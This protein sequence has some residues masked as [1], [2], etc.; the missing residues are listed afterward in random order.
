MKTSQ[1]LNLP[2]ESRDT[3]V[4]LAVIA[5]TLMP[6]AWHLPAWCI[7]LTAVLL[8]WRASLAWGARRLPPTAVRTGMLALVVGLTWLSF[9]TVIGKDPG[10]TL[11]VMLVV[12]KTLE[13]RAR[14]D[15][16]VVFF[17][18]FFL[19]ITNFFYSQSLPV[20]LAMLLAVWGLLTALVL[21][22]IP[23]G[24]P[25]LRHASAIA[26]RMAAWSLPVMV[27]MFVMFPRL[28]PLWGADASGK[29]STGL[30]NTLRMGSIAEL[31]NNTQIAFRIKFEGAAPPPSRLYFRGP[32]LTRFDGQDW[33]PAKSTDT[34]NGQPVAEMGGTTIA[35]EMA[36][37]P[38]NFTLLP[39][40]EWTS[41]IDRSNFGNE[42]PRLMSDMQWKLNRPIDER[43]QFKATGHA[44]VKYGI[45]GSDPSVPESLVLPANSNPRTT[46]WALSLAAREPALMGANVEELVAH[47]LR[48]INSGYTYTLS[49]GSYGD[50]RG[51][52]AIDEFWLDRR[53]GFCEHFATALVFILRTMGVPSRIVTGYQG[54]DV[55]LQD[56]WHVVRQL[57]AHA[58]VEVWTPTRGWW[59]VD[60][61]AAVAPERVMQGQTLRPTPNLMASMIDSL[62][63]S[64]LPSLR[65]FWETSQM[66]WNQWVVQYSRGRQFDILKRL[67]VDKPDWQH[68]LYGVIGLLIATSLVGAA[69]AWWDRRRRDPW[70][71]LQSDMREQLQ[72]L[73]VHAQAHDSPRTLAKR[74][75]EELGTQGEDVARALDAL[76]Q[77]RYAAPD[78][79]LPQP[80]WWRGFA[81]S[82]TTASRRA[83]VSAFSSSMMTR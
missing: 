70:E 32:V 74:V 7:I 19:I 41:F 20:A 75:R 24:R 1:M 34:P 26:A 81:K 8:V 71:R 46:A 62:Q 47:L 23:S 11:L 55:P 13:L 63:P 3:L 38:S 79:A 15:A 58:W 25:S 35:Y 43:L 54:A 51:R 37:E 27:V 67:G 5:W 72:Y 16:L 29:G 6:H 53:E 73:G 45:N 65:H 22:N 17:L 59:R 57:N 4:L 28:G 39:A 64:L 52:L 56:G 60:P 78:G 2:R 14:R 68:L 31:V 10:V 42:A 18:G 82:V 30:S 9:G 12:I 36:M 61:T 49:P 66:R 76:D 80:Q 77:Y 83:A 69:W 44:Q 21:A 48:H 50:A 40:L 33:T